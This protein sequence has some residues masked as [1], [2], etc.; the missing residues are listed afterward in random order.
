MRAGFFPPGSAGGG[1][2]RRL[3][4]RLG[5]DQGLE[6]PARAGGGGSCGGP[7]LRQEE[8]DWTGSLAMRPV[9]SAEIGDFQWNSWVFGPSS[10]D[11][12]SRR[13]AIPAGMSCARDPLDLSRPRRQDRRN[14]SGIL[15]QFFRRVGWISGV[16]RESQQGRKIVS[17]SI[18][19]RDC[20][21]NCHVLR[22]PEPR[23]APR[24]WHL[25]DAPRLR[26]GAQP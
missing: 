19:D 3:C 16:P 1:G 7:F 14:P 11:Q 22:A 17:R 9:V 21:R 15:R 8:P 13:S 24:A 26:R 5:S 20:V 23:T 18:M 12:G 4:G 10:N 6:P 25:S 2:A